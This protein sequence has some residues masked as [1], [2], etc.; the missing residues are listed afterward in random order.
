MSD[1]V[2]DA[3]PQLDKHRIKTQKRV[4]KTTKNEEYD[5]LKQYKI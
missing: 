5:D 2:Y 4:L 3:C 1:M